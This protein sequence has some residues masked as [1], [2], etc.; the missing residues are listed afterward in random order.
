MRVGTRIAALVLAGLAGAGPVFAQEGAAQHDLV[1][2]SATAPQTAPQSGNAPMVVETPPADIG[3]APLQIMTIDPEALFSGSLW[4][5]R[6][7]ADLERQRRDIAAENERLEKQFATEEQELTR[8]RAT[9]SAEDFRKRADDFDKRVVEVRQE[10]DKIAQEWQSSED[11]ARAAFLN[12]ALPV[13]AQLMKERGATVVLDQR[14]I[15]V[16]AQSADVTPVLIERLNAE[17]GA[18][19]ADAPSAPRPVTNP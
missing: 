4:G 2:P 3:A 10:R 14:A 12:A 11:R 9:L 17:L 15:F 18:G 8:L 5:Q 19:V 16:S 7:Q 1:D 6:V 13:L